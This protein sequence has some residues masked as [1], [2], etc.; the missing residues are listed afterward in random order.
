MTKA[1]Y[2]LY[3]MTALL[4]AVLLLTTKVVYSSANDLSRFFT[5]RSLVERQS[6]VIYQHTSRQYADTI[7]LPH[8]G[9]YS[10]K[11]PLL[12]ISAAGAFWLLRTIKFL[13]NPVLSPSA[14]AN[15]FVLTLLLAALPY[16]LIIRL[17]YRLVS[18]F[19]FPNS[20][21]LF[22]L[23]IGSCGTLLFPFATVSNN[24]VLTAALAFVTFYWLL[25]SPLTPKIIVGI[26]L[27]V[28]IL[29][30]IDVPFGSIWLI[31]MTAL[32]WPQIRRHPWHYLAA[33]IPGIILTLYLNWLTS[34]SI[35][36]MYLTA[37][38]YLSLPENSWR[39]DLTL[40][41]PISILYNVFRALLGWSKGLFIY[42][43][44]LLLGFW[45]LLRNGA[46]K[47]SRYQRHVLYWGSVAYLVGVV[48]ITNDLGGA[49]YG[50]RWS[51]PLVP[52]WLWAAVEYW[53]QLPARQRYIWAIIGLFSLYMA[54]GGL[55]DP[56]RSGQ[57]FTLW[58]LIISK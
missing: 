2:P 19:Q 25:R 16:L 5:V 36:P 17:W 24:H 46:S 7:Y 47:L 12:S 4:L 30:A 43:P 39:T 21:Q 3:I 23:I 20:W 33:V 57:D 8:R 32:L 44:I 58:H 28:G 34:G 37:K 54:F 48:A 56:W 15:Y 14:N 49:S 38:D 6:L 22:W 31:M 13:H 29:P 53:P 11:P 1:N 27:L 40:Q 9:W 45:A 42:T 55:V 35:L 52:I 18:S 51:L 10:D 50:L 26:G 41:T